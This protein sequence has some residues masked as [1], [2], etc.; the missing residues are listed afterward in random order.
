VN[1]RKLLDAIV[2]ISGAPKQKFKPICSAIDKLDKEPWSEVRKELIEEKGLTAEIADK[3]GK[4]VEFKGAP[5]ELLNKMRNE[6]IFG[7]SVMGKAG[8]EDME[9]LFKYLAAFDCLK[10]ISFDLSLARGLE[11]YTGMIY[12]AVL[13]G[14]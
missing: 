5:I 9:L 14:T 10:N 6:G 1:N 11:Y 2:E 8:L 4:F 3:I 7:N 12:E 13:V